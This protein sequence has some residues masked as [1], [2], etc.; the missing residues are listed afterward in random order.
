MEEIEHKSLGYSDITELLVSNERSG[1]ITVRNFLTCVSE[2][3]CSSDLLVV[4]TV[5]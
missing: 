1:S 3:F 5:T 4:K 2:V